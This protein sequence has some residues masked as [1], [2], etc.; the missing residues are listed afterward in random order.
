MHIVSKQIQKVIDAH[1]FAFAVFVVLFSFVF[2][3]GGLVVANGQTLGPS[4]SHVVNLYIDGEQ[5]V[6]PSRA[7][8]VEELLQNVGVTL[9]ENDLVEP[10]LKTEID[11]DNFSVQI[12]RAKPV[13]IVDG[14]KT[15]QRIMTPY[16]SERLIAE[17]AGVE[18]YPED[19]VKLENNSF[20]Q[21]QIL[22]KKIVIDRATAVTLSLYGAP[23]GTYR[24]HAN[25]VGDLLKENNIE[26]EEG[27]TVVPGVETKLSE[28][29]PIF[30][31]KLGKK[32]VTVEEEVPFATDSTADPTLFV[33]TTKV[34]KPGVNGKKQVVYEVEL[35]DGKE[36]SKRVL[37]EVVLV[38][39][40]SQQQLRGTK[41]GVVTGDK[42]S[43]MQAAGIAES[44]MF[45]VD[46]IIGHESHWRPNATNGSGCAGLGQACPGSKLANACP[47]WQTDPVCQLRF[48]S[49]YAGRYGGWQGALSAWQRQHWW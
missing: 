47:Q 6:V 17:K 18:I 44:D 2:F 35:R 30:I 23:A 22:G 25:T 40:Q 14:D 1:A 3:A 13:T 49:G 42:V 9:R 41:Q 11:S 37:Q 43:W 45:A 12:H 20:V 29:M 46:F 19:V 5:K 39:P 28:G 16:T 15:P 26:P 38:Q 24:T 10:A 7:G 33:G 31:S 27:A 21:E 34:T 36:V 48:F 32:V 4:D 8:T